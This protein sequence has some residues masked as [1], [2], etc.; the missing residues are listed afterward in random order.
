MK[1]LF[2]TTHIGNMSLKNRFVR[3]AIGEKTTNGH[4]NKNILDLYK[5]LAQGSVGT[6]ITGFT[7]VDEAEKSYPMMAFCDDSFAEGHK[8]LTDTV[9]AHD[10][11]II[12]QLVHVGSYVMGDTTGVSVLAPSVVENL[13]TKA[14]PKEAAIEQIKN[15]QNNFAAA[16]LRAK[17]AGYDGVEIHAAHGFF[18][19]QFMTPYYNHRS[20]LYGGCVRNRARMV[21]E[22]YEQI[23]KVVGSDYPVLIKINVTDGIDGGV[24]FNDV[25]YL[26]NE[27]S[28]RKADAIEISGNWRN[29]KKQSAYFEYEAKSIAAQNETAVILTGGNS[30]FK[31][32]SE[33]LN[34]TKIS[35][36]G[37]ARALAEEPDLINKF[38]MEYN[39]F[40]P[41]QIT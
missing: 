6:I 4:V 26:C 15:I 39:K 41:F 22:T 19:S 32:M 12:L 37:M 2:D 21:L 16:A 18:L 7:L 27:L 29:S 8:T 23:R 34:S 35:Y 36:F 11:N 33:I 31:A 13:N 20:D 10:A 1:T 3:A 5:N 17:N 9:H 40:V 25:L 28:N 24:S 30:D 38:M 14:I